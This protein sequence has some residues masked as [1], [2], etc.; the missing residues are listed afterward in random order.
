M[1]IH[2]MNHFTIVADDADVALAVPKIANAAFR[3]AGQVCTSVQ[4]LLVDRRILPAFL[5]EFLED[6]NSGHNTIATVFLQCHAM[7]RATGPEEFKPVGETEFVAGIGAMKDLG[8]GSAEIKSMRTPAAMRHRGAAQRGAFADQPRH[9][10]RDLG[11][12]GRKADGMH[13]INLP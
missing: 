8:D 12:G 7:Y 5:P 9:F 11:A 3:K 13:Q 1:A 2:G 6:L 10:R 4:R